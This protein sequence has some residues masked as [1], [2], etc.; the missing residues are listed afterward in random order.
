MP[1]RNETGAADIKRMAG[2][3]STRCRIRCK[4]AIDARK[5]APMIGA[6]PGCV[7]ESALSANYE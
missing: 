7:C 4:F 2:D 1:R 3:V 6:C 5:M